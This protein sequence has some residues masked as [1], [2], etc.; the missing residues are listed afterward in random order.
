MQR[1]G[2]PPTPVRF[3]ICMQLRLSAA[4]PVLPRT[5]APRPVLQDK[6]APTAST[7]RRRRASLFAE[8]SGA[9]ARP[10]QNTRSTLCHF[11]HM[12]DISSYPYSSCKAFHRIASHFRNT[13]HKPQNHHMPYIRSWLPPVSVSMAAISRSDAARVGQPR[14][15]HY[16][17]ILPSP[18]L[19]TDKLKPT[20]K[21]LP[22]PRPND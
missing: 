11:R 8:R 16:P 2:W 13:R 1:Q 17:V 4:A 20:R 9:L 15:H 21:E 22:H 5:P 12:S 6:L 19:H 14:T 18:K 3:D 10:S 7:T